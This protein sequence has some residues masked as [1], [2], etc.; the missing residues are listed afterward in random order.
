MITLTKRKRARLAL[1]MLGKQ[2]PPR[3]GDH[4]LIW[5]RVEETEPMTVTVTYKTLRRAFLVQRAL[6]ELDDIA[7]VTPE[8]PI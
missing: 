6:V 7:L 1:Q 2:P 3:I 8:R 4:V 5:A